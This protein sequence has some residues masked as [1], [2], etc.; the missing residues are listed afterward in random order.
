MTYFKENWIG[1]V[2]IAL[3]IFSPIATGLIIGSKVN[4]AIT[5]A[6]GNVTTYAQLTD[7][8]KQRAA[9]QLWVLNLNSSTTEAASGSFHCVNKDGTEAK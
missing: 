3:L 9:T 8:C 2:F 6:I 7:Y 1:F 5:D 4:G